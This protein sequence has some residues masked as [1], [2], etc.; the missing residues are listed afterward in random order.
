MPT[1]N[2]KKGYKM[3]KKVFTDSF[4]KDCGYTFQYNYFDI[5]NKKFKDFTTDNNARLFVEK[6]FKEG[7]GTYT[8]VVAV[9]YQ[10]SINSN[11]MWEFE[12]ECK[13]IDELIKGITEFKYQGFG[14][15]ETF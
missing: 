4:L 14:Y 11:V 8:Q 3:S 10:E 9:Y 6:D 5:A 1:I 2:R 12:I 15:S 13:N 7:K